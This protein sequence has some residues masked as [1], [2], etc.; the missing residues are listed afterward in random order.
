MSYPSVGERTVTTGEGNTKGTMP[1]MAYLARITLTRVKSGIAGHGVWIW[2][3][4]ISTLKSSPVSV[5][6][7]CPASLLGDISWRVTTPSQITW[8]TPRKVTMTT[9][10]VIIGSKNPAGSNANWMSEVL[11]RVNFN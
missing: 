11:L 1:N 5:S 6:V 3:T 7:D 4:L 8:G 9:T 2:T 10:R